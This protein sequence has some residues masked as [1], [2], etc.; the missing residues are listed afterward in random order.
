[1]TS[2]SLSSRL[3]HILRTPAKKK[4]LIGVKF[5]EKTKFHKIKHNVCCGLGA[6]FFLRD[7][8]CFPGAVHTALTPKSGEITQTLNT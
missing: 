7:V 4:M 6:E 5:G 8:Q 2:F 3:F 1:M